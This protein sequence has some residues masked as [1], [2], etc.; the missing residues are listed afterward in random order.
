M[1]LGCCLSGTA[2][3]ALPA[4]LADPTDGAFDLSQHLL[5]RRGFLPVPI[6]ITEPALGYGLGAAAVYFDETVAAKNRDRTAAQPLAPPNIS[7]VGGFK[8]ENGSWGA[9]AGMFRSWREDRFRY[10]GGLGK[11]S[12][13]LDFYGPL[14]RPRS[15]ELEG[16]GLVQQL[17]MRLG[18]SHWML[19]G[20]Y[21]FL[22]T[23]SDFRP[24]LP[25]SIRAAELDV[26]IGKLGLLLNYDSRDNI[27]TPNRG[28][29]AE[30]ELS[31]A[32]DWLGSSR[33]F[34]NLTARA[35]HYMPL[36]EALVL[37]LRGDF[38]SVTEGVPFFALPYIGL[39]GIPALR[40][41]D[42]RTAVVETEL[43][44]NVTPR[45]ALVGFTGA[46]RA[47]GRKVDFADAATQTSYGAG[48]RYLVARRLGLYV[49]LDVARGPEQD[50]FYIQVGSAWR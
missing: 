20:R 10:L 4:R 33:E 46:G 42:R 43:R 41:Q 35:F 26:D 37:G 31:A 28:T 12:L 7:A 6:I 45:W 36:G 11:V 19:G 34:E 15:Y 40:Y 25:P 3:G 14:N 27:L 18:Q 8:T 32:R 47:F 23:K 21:V 50:A 16:L 44:W 9:G 29:F 49:G 38:Q 5:E 1:L 30:L 48:I 39:R 13:N 2:F 22:S 17:S 24:P